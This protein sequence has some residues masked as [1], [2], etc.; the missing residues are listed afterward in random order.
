MKRARVAL[1]LVPL[2]APAAEPDAYFEAKVRPVLATH[3]YGCHSKKAKTVFA[4]LRVDSR[5]ALLRGGDHGPA[6]VPGKPASSRMVQAIRWEGLRMPPAGKLGADEIAV[7]ERWIEMDAP[8]PEEAGGGEAASKVPGGGG[9]DHWALQAVRTDFP[10]G[11]TIDSFL[12]AKLSESGLTANPAADRRTLIRRLSYD[13]TGLPPTAEEIEAFEKDRDA[14]A[15]E[16]VVEG[17][18]ASPRFGERWAR[19][20]LD[21]ARFSD[22][23]FNNIRFPYAY[24]YRDWVIGA[25]NSDMR[26][27]EFV[28][29][30]LAADQ[31]GEDKEARKHLAALGFLA[32][33]YNAPR[34]ANEPEK[35]DDRIDT[36]TRTF[37]GLTVSCA[38]C[39]DHKYDPIPTGDYYAL[40]GVF[41]NAQELDPAPVDPRAGGSERDRFYE[42]LLDRRQRAIDEYKAARIEEI[43]AE[44]RQP[45]EVKKYLLAAWES[46]EMTNPQVEAISKER[47]INLRILNRWREWMQGRVFDP[48]EAEAVVSG[49]AASGELERPEAPPSVPLEDFPYVL[50]EGDY[51]TT[52]NLRWHRDMLYAD[53]AL[54][55]SPAR[56]MAVADKATIEGAHVFIRG[57]P[58]DW[59]AAV[60]R[61]FLSALSKGEPAAFTHGAGRLDLARA[62]AD[63]GNPLTA[64]VYVNRVWSHLFGA[65]IVTTVSDF[66]TR[67]G[68]PSH[69]ELLDFLAARF[70]REGWST[71]R[72][73]REIVVSAAYRRSSAANGESRA[74]DPENRLL[75]RQNR[76][77]L[78]FESL[79]DSMLVAAGRLDGTI[80]GRSFALDAVP[81]DPRRTMYA[82][83]ERERAHPLLKAFSYADPERHTEERPATTVPQQSLFLMN[84]PFVAEQARHLAERA[85]DARSM[86]RLALGRD[87]SAEEAAAAGEWF[88]AAP[89][90]V[91]AS[92]AGAWESGHGEFDPASGQVRSFKPFRYFVEGKWQASS[93]L[94]DGEAGAAYLT[95]NGG[96]PGDDLRHAAIR[97]WVAPRDVTVK[98]R[99]TLGHALDQFEQR[100][101]LSD[102]IR[103]HIVHS[104]SGIAGRWEF[105]PPV[106]S[107]DGKRAE[108]RKV[109]TV[110][111]GLAVKAG[112]T[113]DFVVD[114]NGT[115][116]SD[117]FTWAPEIVA[118]ESGWSASKE[119]AGPAPAALSRREQLAQVLLLTNEFAFID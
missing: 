8:W 113:I 107:E 115:Y 37:L 98:I 42:S 34:L 84:S 63:A 36:V 74:K 68:T 59:G 15:Y 85:G 41:A 69:P 10:A 76:R 31:R 66:G 51:N 30:Q 58:N 9:R 87:P 73:I 119:F 24:T 50:T 17:M 95:A 56:A 18:L 80:G 71:K 35:V 53:Y 106:Y 112:D 116:E 19:H 3:C 54:R 79:R 100:F 81:A 77:R 38:R 49:L 117:D 83:V 22:A 64:R 75:W 44:A 91:P 12:D 70:M 102:G 101:G 82:Y 92:P 7:I 89:P 61:R 4:G 108:T 105:G 33:G 21:L 55:Q 32:L 11:A 26:Y 62:I 57:N 110:V 111:E 29:R 25:Y 14:R 96:S 40:Y 99:G 43:R 103:A 13:L 23:G 109:E 2:L 90:G 52:N 46:R 114:S 27:D 48:A 47:N 78:D 67:G 93:L 6:L 1:M 16:R 45:A 97:R 88:A 94:P 72:L 28:T 5:G 65:G 39:H 86:Y 118:G 104:G 20:W 60:P